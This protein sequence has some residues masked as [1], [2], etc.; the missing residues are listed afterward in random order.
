MKANPPHSPQSP[1]ILLEI[2]WYYMTTTSTEILIINR[3]WR[4][5]LDLGTLSTIRAV[6]LVINGLDFI[7]VPTCSSCPLPRW[8]M[9]HWLSIGM[10]G[11]DRALQSYHV[12]H[13]CTTSP[14]FISSAI[15]KHKYSKNITVWVLVMGAALIRQNTNPIWQKYI[16]YVL[17][18]RYDIGMPW[19]RQYVYNTNTPVFFFFF[20]VLDT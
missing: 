12:V 4:L 8:N 15:M 1:D 16:G 7:S 14:W 6:R 11:L 10:Y 19:V 5:F 2:L 13:P 17:A 18:S 20:Y 9:A 3:N